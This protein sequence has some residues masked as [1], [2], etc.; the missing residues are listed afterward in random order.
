MYLYTHTHTHT[1]TRTY[2]ID[3]L[4]YYKYN[5]TTKSKLEKLVQ[6]ILNMGVIMHSK[7][8][9]ENLVVDIERWVFLP[10]CKL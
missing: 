2:N 7:I 5:H 1:H 6:E 9:Y 3:N 4:T 8:P 10:T